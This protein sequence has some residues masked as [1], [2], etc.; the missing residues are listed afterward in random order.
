LALRRPIARRWRALQPLQRQAAY[1]EKEPVLTPFTLSFVA[2]LFGAAG[3]ALAQSADAYTPPAPVALSS[4]APGGNALFPRHWVRGYTDFEF[5]P[6][7]NEPDLG[8]CRASAGQFGGAQARCAAFARYML[9]GYVEARPFGQTAL[10]HVFLFA[11]PRLFLGNNVPQISYTAAATP[12]AVESTL[13]AGIELG[14]SFEV[15]AVRHAV[16]WQGRY[17]SNLG[18]ADIQPTGPYGHYATIGVRWFF[19]GY[20]GETR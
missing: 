4:V 19:G 7:T 11:M 20:G 8:R 16:Y 12:I 2:V 3:P 14:K 9:S 10:R 6:P 17:R 1:R 5:A 18:Y 15:R 13:G